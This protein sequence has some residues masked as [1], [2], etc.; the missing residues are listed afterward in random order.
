VSPAVLSRF[1]TQRSNLFTLSRNSHSYCAQ[2]RL[3]W[4]DEGLVYN[5]L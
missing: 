5:L 3:S 1:F 2:S 4:P